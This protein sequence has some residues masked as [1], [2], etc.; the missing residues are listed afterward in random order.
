MKKKS[1]LFLFLLFWNCFLFS[2]EYSSFQALSQ[3][4]SISGDVEYVIVMHDFLDGFYITYVENKTLKVLHGSAGVDTLIPYDPYLNGHLIT[5]VREL[6]TSS[7]ASVVERGAFL[8]T[9]NG[10][11]HLYIFYI[12]ALGRFTIQQEWADIDSSTSTIDQY[13]IIDIGDGFLYAYYSRAGKLYSVY[14]PLEVPGGIQGDTVSLS[15]ESVSNFDIIQSNDG[16]I[17]GWYITRKLDQADLV[18]F[19]RKNGMTLQRVS[20]GYGSVGNNKLVNVSMSPLFDDTVRYLVNI[21]SIAEVYFGNTYGI[22]REYHFNDTSIKGFYDLDFLGI[23]KNLMILVEDGR[24]SVHIVKK[25]LD[26][27]VSESQVLIDNVENPKLAIF[28]LDVSH[29]MVVAFAEGWKSVVFDITGINSTITTD[30]PVGTQTS[31]LLYSDCSDVPRLVFCDA[32]SGSADIEGGIISLIFNDGQWVVER[33]INIDISERE[34]LLRNA[35]IPR[36]SAFTSNG[37]TL[38]SSVYGSGLLFIDLS[39]ENTSFIR[40]D[41]YTWS[42]RINEQ[43]YLTIFEDKKMIIYGNNR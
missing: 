30:I 43:L 17:Y 39:M 37:D 34:M 33:R 4:Y 9:E 32:D 24:M 1:I 41:L 31:A 2:E 22:R 6:R 18:L 20:A 26:E 27:G 36:L 16:V 42:R 28:P 21:G 10:I 35:D 3:P 5:N 7:S 19:S 11:E 38:V 13:Q 25:G 15:G 29:L 12:N 40:A 8:G 14:F 23:D